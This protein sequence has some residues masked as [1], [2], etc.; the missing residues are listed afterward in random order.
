MLQ[1]NAYK[2]YMTLRYPDALMIQGSIGAPQDNHHPDK[3]MTDVVNLMVNTIIVTMLI[4]LITD[5]PS[6]ITIFRE[7]EALKCHLTTYK[8]LILGLNHLKECSLTAPTCL[9]K[10][11]AQERHH[12]L[13]AS[14]GITVF[15]ELE[16]PEYHHHTHK[17]L[18]LNLNHLKDCSITAPTRL[19]KYEDP[20]C[21][22]PTLMHLID[23]RTPTAPWLMHLRQHEDPECH[24]PTLMHLIDHLNGR[25]PTA[26][27]LMYPRQHEDPE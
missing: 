5:A 15:Y 12:N 7:Q 25:T 22:H 6:A 27:R 18:I 24:H 17:H 19:F 2:Q 1:L 8:H 23:H 21:Y 10:H 3:G 11:G 14:S 20:E 16:V 9:L 4:Q 26:P 13:G